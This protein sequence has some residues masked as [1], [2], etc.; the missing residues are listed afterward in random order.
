M[1]L[2]DRKTFIIDAVL[3][4]AEK[5]VIINNSILVQLIVKPLTSSTTYDIIIEDEDNNEIYKQEDCQ[6]TFNEVD[7]SIPS[8]GNWMVKIENASVDEAF[9]IILGLRRS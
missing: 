6:G 9:N 5:Q 2:I 3:G 4:V 8:G 7:V 1:I